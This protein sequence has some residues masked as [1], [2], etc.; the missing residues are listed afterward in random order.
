MEQMPKLYY[1]PPSVRMPNVALSTGARVVEKW[2]AAHRQEAVL[3]ML[4]LG[5]ALAVGALAARV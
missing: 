1:R 3:W 5:L 4:V 2:W